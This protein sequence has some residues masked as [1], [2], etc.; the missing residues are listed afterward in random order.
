MSSPA[1]G[2]AIRR[3]RCLRER[4]ERDILPYV[5]RPTRYL[6][7]ELN[8]I[9]KDLDTVR[10]SV[11]FCFPDKYEVG[12]SHLGLHL[13]YK[14]LNDR[15][16][17]AAERCFAPD[18]D[19]EELLRAKGLPLC[20]LESGWPL[21]EVDIVAFTLQY[22]LCY[23]NLLAM[24]DLAGMPLEGAERGDE[25]PLVIAGGSCTA[26]PEPLAD[27]V[28]LFVIGDGEEVI[29]ELID[30]YQAGQRSGAAR[31]EQLRRLAEI[32]GVYAPSLFEVSYNDDGSIARIDASRAPS[33][34]IERRV[35]WDLNQAP[36]PVEPVVPFTRVVHERVAIEVARGC[37]RGC[38]FCEAGYIMRP[39]RERTPE[40]IKR[41]I[42]RSLRN[43]GFQDVSLMSLSTGDYSALDSM[44]HELTDT[45][46]NEGVSISLPSLRPGS[47]NPQLVDQ[48]SRVRK[49]GF[50]IA[51]EAGSERLRNVINK[52][53][54]EAD[55]L[56]NV[57]EIVS[58]GWESVKFYFMIGLPTETDE[59]LDGIVRLCTESLNI[60]GANGRRLKNINLGISTFVP[61][62]HT[63]F[64][65]FPQ[66]RLEI[67]R[68]KQ[69]Y[70]I[71]R[72]KKKPVHFRFHDPES[73]YLEAV[74]S[75]GDRRIGRAL[76][77]AFELGCRFD[78][79]DEHFDHSIWRRAFER[80]GINPEFY[81]WRTL[82]DD[83][84]LPWNHIDSHTVKKFHRRDRQRATRSQAL[85]DCRYDACTGCGPLLGMAKTQG[86][87]SYCTTTKRDTAWFAYRNE[88]GGADLLP[89][90]S[91]TID[92]PTL[93]ASNGSGSRPAAIAAHEPRRP[94]GN[95]AANPQAARATGDSN[96]PPTAEP[97]TPERPTPPHRG[98][99]AVA[100]VIRL[101]YS[102]RSLMKYLSQLELQTVFHRALRRLTAP[103]AHSRGFSPHPKISFGPA[104]PVGVESLEEYCDLSL[105]RWM[106]PDLLHHALNRELPEGLRIEG[107]EDITLL[108]GL[109]LQPRSA[110]Y[111]VTVTGTAI[112]HLASNGTRSIA[113][114]EVLSAM[115]R[116]FLARPAIEVLKG[117]NRPQH[118]GKKPR[119]VDV[120]PFIEEF[121]V[122][123]CD[124]ARLRLNM[125][126]RVSH[127][128]GVKPMALVEE[129][130][131]TPA[132]ALEIN[133]LKVA[134]TW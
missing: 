126:L 133:V 34:S 32:K 113:A 51:P 4:F 60:R 39:T 6:G 75:R 117:G 77:A 123:A 73:S 9:R 88:H 1:I 91:S 19:C 13:L 30:A 61:K 93:P 50:T 87:L 109:P 14:I 121:D 96:S 59:D 89:R 64:Q 20:T 46:G 58:A 40:N 81:A 27:F 18:L 53:I 101:C 118:R 94:N 83:E 130:L 80:A 56:R 12:M 65:W 114:D 62:P 38:R 99:A 33:A 111:D 127:E 107:A 119:L 23:T 29:H 84:V 49:S 21:G 28:D 103:L 15:A 25:H 92:A 5:S 66:A 79:W 67:I 95:G 72:L 41:L 115:A 31:H 112:E 125:R 36:W 37:T 105:T 74:F 128:G 68:A 48:I 17:V 108:P 44:V 98:T 2:D 69:D 26:N 78:A 104:L 110:L 54:S 124:G 131:Q 45:F 11:A 97:Q 132:G 102:K 134:Q 57:Y 71:Q 8:S 16:D 116:D 55:L 120:R 122:V 43:T 7:A 106:A 76:R 82:A 24:L 129:F 10:T 22:D 3:P 63:P 42:H 52:T 90:A 85:E 70:L 35:I 86:G 47:L 100:Q